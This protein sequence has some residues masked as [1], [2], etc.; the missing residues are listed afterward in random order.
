MPITEL[1]LIAGIEAKN[2]FPLDPAQRQAIQYG[3]GPLLIAAGPGTGKT[4]VLV[5]RCL[6]FIS[7]DSVQ[8]ASIM[9]TT[10]TEKAAKNLQ[11]R[12]SEAFL[13]LVGM[14]PQLAEADPSELRIGTLHG[15][16]ND[17]LQE[18][19]YTA[20]Q[21]LRLLD[22]VDSALLLRKS[23]V[24][25][26]NTLQPALF[27]QFNYLFD[28]KPQVYLSKWDWALALQQLLDRLIE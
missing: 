15:L 2:G 28:N 27:A 23:V 26:I 3:A 14:Y 6:K 12:L 16:C 5:A 8:P 10:F 7:C 20:Y 1:E 11:D 25:S 22:E 24:G 19:R 4:E 18:Y 9:L 21:N 13:F 17:V